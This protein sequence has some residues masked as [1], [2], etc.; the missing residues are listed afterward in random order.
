MHRV[1]SCAIFVDI[2]DM[3]PQGLAA[4]QKP[5]RCTRLRPSAIMV[6]RVDLEVACRN[7]CYLKAA[8]PRIQEEAQRV[9]S[10]P[11]AGVE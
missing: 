10:A 3:R 11:A 2:L 8:V 4:Y 9:R 5:S 1:L 7:E 6:T